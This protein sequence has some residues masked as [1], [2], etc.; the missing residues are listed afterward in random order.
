MNNPYVTLQT[1]DKDFLNFIY[2]SP[3]IKVCQHKEIYT[4]FKTFL[5]ITGALIDR[6]TDA[7]FRHNNIVNIFNVSMCL[8][9]FYKK[10]K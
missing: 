1:I 9:E 2:T 10:K 3:I 6:S 4:T 8:F 5:K 7:Y